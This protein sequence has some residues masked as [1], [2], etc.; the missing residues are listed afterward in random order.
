MRYTVRRSEVYVIGRIW[1]GQ[2]CAYTY[3][4]PGNVPN[5]L[6]RERVADWLARNSGDFAS[7]EDFAASIEDLASTI[8]IPWEN[9][10]SI[11]T[12]ADCME[13]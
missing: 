12:F 8:E 7:I 1:T 5:L 4:I 6:T 2:L 13:G 3:Q 9:E 10:E 11:L